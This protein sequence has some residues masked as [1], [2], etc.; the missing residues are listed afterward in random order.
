MGFKIYAANGA[1]T[2][3]YGEQFLQLELGLHRMV[4]WK[5]CV[6]DVAWPIIGLDFSI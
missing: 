3:T 5:F 6:A 1:I 4:K 2:E